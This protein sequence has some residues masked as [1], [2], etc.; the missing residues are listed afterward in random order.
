MAKLHRTEFFMETFDGDRFNISIAGGQMG[1]ATVTQGKLN[2]VES[3]A[4]VV[5]A[6][7]IE[8]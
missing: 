1:E 7:K 8:K 3:K 5:E 2:W 6:H 4:P